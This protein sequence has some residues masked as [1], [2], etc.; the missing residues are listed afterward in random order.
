MTTHHPHH[1]EHHEQPHH[2]A[3]ARNTAEELAPLEYAPSTASQPMTFTLQTTPKKVFFAGFIAG[4]LI[5]ALPTVYF[6]TRS[7]AVADTSSDTVTVGTPTPSGDQPTPSAPSP[8]KVKQVGKEDYVF[9]NKNAEV[10]L[11]EYS[12]LECPFCQRFHTT[13]KQALDEYKGK[14]NWAYRHFPL[15]FHANAQKEAEASEC[16]GELGGSKKYYEYI[17]AIFA[18]TTATGTGFSLDNLVPL[19]KELKL[20][21]GKFKSCLDGGKYTS[22]IQQS[23][24]EGQEAGVDGTPGT[25]LVTKDGKSALVAGAV[26]LEELKA[27]IDALLK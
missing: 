25:I 27:Q 12:D 16:A 8:G 4:L 18:R 1:G 17:D 26:P 7:N 21:E 24:K 13:I 11:I 5:M 23:L 3:E 2:D 10:T 20:N 19:A 14:V 22:K 9:G 6:A 15:S